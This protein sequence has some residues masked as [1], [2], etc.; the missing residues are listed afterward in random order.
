[1]INS[2][3]LLLVSL[4]LSM[5][6]AQ[7]PSDCDVCDALFR[8]TQCESDKYYEPVSNRCLDCPV[9][10]CAT[11]THNNGNCLTC[12]QGKYL[13]SGGRGTCPKCADGC[14]EC[15]SLD[16]CTSCDYSYRLNGNSCLKINWWENYWFWLAYCCYCLCCLLLL[17]ILALLAGL[18]AMLLGTGAGRSKTTRYER[19][20]Y[21]DDGNS[22][23]VSSAPV[24]QRVVR[25][26]YAQPVQQRVVRR[27]APLTMDV[28]RY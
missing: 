4:V 24:T 23:Y 11:C 6:L 22:S 12:E 9:E 3:T 7:C 1:M 14:Y 25:R 8:C 15:T 28:A 19:H 13:Q 5:T 10:D 27:E 17:L 26:T 2:R 20:E 16:V 18:L 21:Y